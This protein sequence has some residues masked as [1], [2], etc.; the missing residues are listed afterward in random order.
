M[1][2]SDS[3]FGLQLRI[4]LRLT[5]FDLVISTIIAKS[6]NFAVGVEV[7]VRALITVMKSAIPAL[8][9]LSIVLRLATIRASVHMYG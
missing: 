2:L 3:E 5:Q 8:I 1:N 7:T 6:L 9:L 4:L